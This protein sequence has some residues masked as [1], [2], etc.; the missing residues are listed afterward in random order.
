MIKSFVEIGPAFGIVVSL[1]RQ[2]SWAYHVAIEGR[3][4]FAKRKQLFSGAV[5]K[6]SHGCQY[7]QFEGYFAESVLG[8]FRIIR[9]FADLRDL[10]AVSVPEV[11]PNDVRELLNYRSAFEFVSE[12]LRQLRDN[13]ATKFATGLR[14]VCDKL[15][16]QRVTRAFRRGLQKMPSGIRAG[17]EFESVLCF[18]IADCEANGK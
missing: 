18:G 12:C 3:E 8:I 6:V 15:A 5:D 14:Q 10:A 11:D 4:R 9:G 16:T 17:I 13:F 7:I 1:A 2:S